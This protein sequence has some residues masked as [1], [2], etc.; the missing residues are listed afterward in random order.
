MS[1]HFARFL[2]DNGSIG[3]QSDFNFTFSLPSFDEPSE[4]IRTIG[5]LV[6]SMEPFQSFQPGE[7]STL[8]STSVHQLV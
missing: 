4:A 2:G 6:R 5:F 8:P 3:F 7:W 1:L